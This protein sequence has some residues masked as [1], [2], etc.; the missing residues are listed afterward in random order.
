MC[1]FKSDITDK[2]IEEGVLYAFRYANLLL[3]LLKI[4]VE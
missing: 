3:V 1:R 2:A 4:A